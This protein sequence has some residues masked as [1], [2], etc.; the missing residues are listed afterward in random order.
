MT[1]VLYRAHETMAMGGVPDHLE[2]RPRRLDGGR[3]GAHDAGH[4]HFPPLRAGDKVLQIRPV[5]RL[6]FI[7]SKREIPLDG[8][9]TE[10]MAEKLTNH[11]VGMARALLEEH[12]PFEI[13]SEH[14]V[15]PEML[16]EYKVVILPQ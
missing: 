7:A 5:H 10:H 12:I 6:L 16:A 11:R 1:E 4:G 13:V 3:L 9:L 2:W 14:N 8:K 15:T